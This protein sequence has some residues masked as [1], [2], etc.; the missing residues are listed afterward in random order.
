VRKDQAK[1]QRQQNVGGGVSIALLMGVRCQL[2]VSE[3]FPPADSGEDNY[4][5][6]EEVV[7]DKNGRRRRETSSTPL[8]KTSSFLV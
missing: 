3:H 6:Y 7:A 8:V 4:V 5:F 1:G 2:P